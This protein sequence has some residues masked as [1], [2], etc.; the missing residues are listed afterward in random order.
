VHFLLFLSIAFSSVFNHPDDN[1][2][3]SQLLKNL[4]ATNNGAVIASPQKKDPNYYYHWVR[5]AALVTNTIVQIYKN[6][7]NVTLQEKLSGW[8]I[9]SIEFTKKIQSTPNKSKGLGEPKFGWDASAFNE[10]WGR[11]QN[12]GPALRA[13]S[14]INLSN[15]LIEEGNEAEALKEIYP[16]I[17]KDLLYVTENWPKPCFDLWEEVYDQHFYTLLVQRKAL[18]L[19]EKL[20]AYYSLSN[21]ELIYKK[22]IYAIENKLKEHWNHKLNLIMPSIPRPDDDRWAN[23]SKEKRNSK[24]S[25][26]DASILLAINHGAHNDNFLAANDSKVLSTVYHFIS[27]YKKNFE[28]NHNSKPGIALGRYPEDIYNGTDNKKAGAWFLITSGLSEFYSK[29]RK[30]LIKTKHIRI[31]DLNLDFYTYI[32]GSTALKPGTLIPS[33][34]RLFQNMLSKIKQK[35]EDQMTRVYAHSNKGHMSEQ[36]DQKTGY[37]MSATDLT[38]SYAA[39]LS[40]R[41]DLE[42]H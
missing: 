6:T 4:D 23:T 27:Y 16:L 36:L 12:D 38:W 18:K 42:T 33:K 14:Y 25:H 19:G 30:K 21:D 37:Q 28:I 8:L 10:D 17:K 39:L 32:L 20:A 7:D 40:A 22:Q 2:A 29:L 24:T 26:L 31:D 15:L 35:A 41:I 1:A 11:P 9:K 13:I 3:L 34:S 5:D